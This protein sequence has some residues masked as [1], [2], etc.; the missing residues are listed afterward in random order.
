MSETDIYDLRFNRPRLPL[1]ESDANLDPER[2]IK[3]AVLYDNQGLGNCERCG[4]FLTQHDLERT[5]IESNIAKE[6]DNGPLKNL[7]EPKYDYLRWCSICITLHTMGYVNSDGTAI[8]GEHNLENLGFA[9]SLIEVGRAFPTKDRIRDS[10]RKLTQELVDLGEEEE[11]EEE[12]EYF[13]IKR[14]KQTD[15]APKDEEI[16]EEIITPAPQKTEQKKRKRV[17]P[18][19]LTPE[20]VGQIEKDREQSKLLQKKRPGSSVSL[21]VEINIEEEKNKLKQGYLNALRFI[22]AF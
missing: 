2:G 3:H 7:T 21:N 6:D 22:S 4:T 16:K 13:P 19:R 18:T 9:R 10:M 8:E 14:L 5:K 11:E 12:E 1:V 15:H 20:Q 17:T